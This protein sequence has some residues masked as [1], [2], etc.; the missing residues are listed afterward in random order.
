[1]KI[2]YGIHLGLSSASIAKMKDGE[3]CIIKSD[4]MRDKLPVCV[5]FNKKGAVQVGDAAFD[6]HKR[7][8]LN[9]QK[10]WNS[11]TQNSFTEFTQ[12]LGTDK[13]YYSS[14]ANKSFSSTELVAEVLKALISLEKD[15]DINAAVITVPDGFKI[16][17]INAVREAGKLAGL[18]QVETVSESFAAALAYGL[19][20]NKEDGFWL[21]FDFGIS[22]FNSALLK[23]EE[24]IMR[25]IDTEGDNYLGGEN[26]DFA[27]VDEIILPYIQENFVIDSFLADDKKKQM[28]RNSLRFYAETAKI[29]LSFSDETSIFSD[30]DGIP[31]EDDEGEE[32]ELDLT[33]TQADITKALSPIFQKAIDISK[34]LLERNNLKGSSL[35]SLILVGGPTFSPVLRK[36]LETQICK[37]DTSADPMTVVSKGAALYA[38]TVDISKE[39]REQTRDKTKIQLEI[40]NESSTVETEEFVPIK[41]LADKTEEEIPKKVFAEVTRGD[42]AWSSG[43]VE[44]NSIGEIVDVALVDEVNNHFDILLYDNEGNVLK[45]EPDS[46]DILQLAEWQVS[47]A[48]LPYNIGIEVE[49]KQTGK[50]VFR[51]IKGLEKN[52]SIPAIG[53]INGFKTEKPIRPGVEA[54]FIK[55]SIYEG[56]HG[57]EGTRVIYNEHI[58][59]VIVSGAD[60]PTL[61]PEDSDIDL[62]ISVDK[63]EKITVTAYFPYLDYS[64]GV[65]VN[66]TKTSI[67]S[68][69]LENEIRNA[70]GS[71]EELKENRNSDNA[72]LQKIETE[73]NQLQ[74]YFKNN[75]NDLDG[76]QEVLTNLRKCLKAIDELNDTTEWP[77]LESKLKNSFSKFN[78]LAKN[79]NN[80]NI[81]NM[82]VNFQAQI[83]EVLKSQDIKLGKCILDLILSETKRIDAINEKYDRE[84]LQLYEN[85]EMTLWELKESLEEVNRQD[86]VVYSEVIMLINKIENGI[87]KEK[88][89]DLLFQLTENERLTGEKFG[90]YFEQ[91]SNLN[92]NDLNLE[93]VYKELKAYE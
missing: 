38:S 53:T 13:V 20:S 71:I 66:S 4:T 57:A 93:S 64:I 78:Q 70:K 30:L 36:M 55:I 39:V 92:D 42:K 59:T 48:T 69:W 33:V 62:T 47:R 31:G 86:G 76:K 16:N 17:Q 50:I 68:S 65:E 27:I 77:K 90:E 5:Y 87:T 79:L 23:V 61:L 26:L 84:Y 74:K 46:F 72:K 83:S 41:I 7:D 81:S 82:A 21:I 9:S 35:N 58:C 32:F 40:A 10:G 51:T 80:D 49:D 52:Q 75:K 1:M 22:C 89:E 54:D 91:L 60:L 43:K 11:S 24:G 37:P 34:I 88:V 63:S 14:N 44:I 15:V 67:E 56:G 45:C 12:T 25:V 6:A 29:K 19:D 2:N 8:A 18:K 85:G 28:L 3:P 73:L